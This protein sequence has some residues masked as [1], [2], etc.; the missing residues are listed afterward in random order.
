MII[1]TKEFK[2][3]HSPSKWQC[4]FSY[5]LASSLPFTSNEIS[6]FCLSSPTNKWACHK[7]EL[8][9]VGTWTRVSRAMKSTTTNR[10]Q[11]FKSSKTAISATKVVAITERCLPKSFAS[12]LTLP[13]NFKYSQRAASLLEAYM[14][15]YI[16]FAGAPT[17]P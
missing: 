11:L 4:F 16:V 9:A 7:L 6:S 3:T 12:I 8:D 2:R 5:F 10:D 17:A 13:F 1:L 15:A 14:H